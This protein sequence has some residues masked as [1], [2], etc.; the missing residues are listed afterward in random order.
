MHST[1]P[2]RGDNI[3]A[4]ARAFR[5]RS[6]CRSLLAQ[7]KIYSVL[8]VITNVLVDQALQMALVEH[9]HVVQQIAAAV[10]HPALAMPFCQGLVKEVRMSF[11]PKHFA[12]SRT[13]VLKV[14]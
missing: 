14:A 12:V 5:G 9:D 1:K 11:A 10:A 4:P 8:E 6:A 13:S 2:Q 3:A 7:P